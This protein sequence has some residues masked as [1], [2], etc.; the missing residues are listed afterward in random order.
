MDSSSCS[1]HQDKCPRPAPF[2]QNDKCPKFNVDTKLWKFNS[3]FSVLANPVPAMQISVENLRRGRSYVSLA[4]N[5]NA[6][7]SLS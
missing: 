6:R 7:N 3:V 4:Q 5:S 2:M 1:F